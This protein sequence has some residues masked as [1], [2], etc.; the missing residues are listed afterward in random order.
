MQVAQEMIGH[1]QQ[2]VAFFGAEQEDHTKCLGALDF[3]QALLTTG[4]S[5][6]VKE[7]NKESL[8]A[9]VN[10]MQLPE[11]HSSPTL[12][13]VANCRTNILRLTMGLA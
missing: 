2:A 13:L 8:R 11:D 3:L 9:T 4:P 10:D 1:C 7:L 6:V 5:G 12:Q